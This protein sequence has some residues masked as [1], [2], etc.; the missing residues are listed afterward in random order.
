MSK[1]LLVCEKKSTT[2]NDTI[3]KNLSL[4][5]NKIIPDNITPHPTL[6]FQ[7]DKTSMY[8]FN[9]VDSVGIK[10]NS[11]CLGKTVE[12][13]YDWSEISGPVPEGTYAIFRTSESEIEL[14]SDIIGS[15]T[16]WYYHDEDYFIASTTQ[17]GIVNCL[18]G[19]EFN[20][21]VIPWMLFSGIIGPD[22]SWDKRIKKLPG[23]TRLSFNITEWEYTLEQKLTVFKSVP[24]T[25]KEAVSKLKSTVQQLLLNLKFDFNHWL[26]TLSG[27]VDSRGLF[28]YLKD[29]PGL[30]TI[31]WGTKKATQS[32]DNDASIAKSIAEK[33]NIAHQYFEIDE[34]DDSF[35]TILERFLHAGEGRVDHIGGYMDGFSIWKKLF[36][37]NVKGVI[38][39]DQG[40]GWVKTRNKTDIYNS[41][42]VNT[43]KTFGN[44]NHW[45]KNIIPSQ[46]LP[47]YFKQRPGEPIDD[48]RDRLYHDFR[49][50]CY[51]AALNDL[52]TP[53]V[54]VSSP[55]FSY[56]VLNLLRSIP[57]KLRTGKNMIKKMVQDFCPDISF[58]KQIAIIDH[59]GVVQN[60][61]VSEYLKNEL[62]KINSPILSNELIEDVLKHLTTDK[63][64][65]SKKNTRISNYHKYRHKTPQWLKSLLRKGGYKKTLN[66]NLLALRV[67]IIHKMYKTLSS[68]KDLI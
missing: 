37:N 56:C 3:I 49:V 62:L 14:L 24:F 2:L 52:K 59:T 13:D 60:K 28:R 65:L 44:I 12:Y 25:E 10:N 47:E 50:A 54:E 21:K 8:L 4:L 23:N 55:Y 34:T 64:E 51:H 36:E 19:F 1:L 20:E 7:N 43:G 40:F 17:R 45:K 33:Y 29:D 61:E 57:G 46:N 31:T 27:G 68:D 67:V 38:R 63:Q 15:R 9:P 16:I 6:V 26:L 58:A 18:K 53:Y 22:Y 32:P 30:K 48:W 39:G 41:I 11:I 42:G 5:T 66:Y 35:E